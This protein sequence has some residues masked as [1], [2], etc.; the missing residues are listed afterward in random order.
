M[1]QT[2]GQN[3]EICKSIRPPTPEDT[4]TRGKKRE[5]S[6][7]SGGRCLHGSEVRTRFAART[8]RPHV[9]QLQT[10]ENRRCAPNH[11]D[12]VL[13]GAGVFLQVRRIRGG[14]RE[15]P[16]RLPQRFACCLD[17]SLFRR[18]RDGQRGGFNYETKI[19]SQIGVRPSW[20]RE[21]HANELGCPSL[22]R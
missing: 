22:R 14:R 4:K 2:G 13:E 9:L 11:G 19:H 17:C 1:F 8:R 7:A 6:W 5:R 18:V 12:V 16:T 21:R 20:G 15:S 3:C 10:D